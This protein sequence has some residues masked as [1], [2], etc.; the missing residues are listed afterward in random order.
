M[1]DVFIVMSTGMNWN[2]GGGGEEMP[3]GERKG[4][5]TSM[6]VE[7][8]VSGTEVLLGANKIKSQIFNVWKS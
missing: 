5:C 3:G 4:R 2:G 8:P 1:S 6:E 7:R